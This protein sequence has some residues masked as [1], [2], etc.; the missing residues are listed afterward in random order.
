MPA[1]AV[2]K[3]FTEETSANYLLHL[4]EAAAH[5][6]WIWIFYSKG[7]DKLEMPNLV[8]MR[9]FYRTV[10]KRY[11][12]I[13]QKIYILNTNCMMNTLFSMIFPFL[14]KQARD[15]FFFVKVHLFF[16]MM[17]FLLKWL[18]NSYLYRKKGCQQFY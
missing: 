1:L 11:A 13:L 7:L 15:L 16:L 3:K 18:K 5:A 17:A 12:G 4:E 6:P 2:E 10:H 8:L 9:A 14:S